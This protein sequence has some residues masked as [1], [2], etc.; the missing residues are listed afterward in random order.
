M[1][2]I[3]SWGVNSLFPRYEISVPIILVL[4]EKSSKKEEEN[5][6]WDKHSWE[7]MCNLREINELLS[8]NVKANRL[9]TVTVIDSERLDYMLGK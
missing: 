6:I 8:C 7:D 2:K 5:R 3:P 1:S 4:I 9:T